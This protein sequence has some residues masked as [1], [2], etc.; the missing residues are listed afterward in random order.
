MQSSTLFSTYSHRR[1]SKFLLLNTVRLLSQMAVAR[2]SSTLESLAEWEPDSAKDR[3]ILERIKKLAATYLPDGWQQWKM[4]P[5]TKE[6]LLGNDLD[7]QILNKI[8][9]CLPTV[10]LAR[11]FNPDCSGLSEKFY[12]EMK[13][14][15]LNWSFCIGLIIGGGPIPSAQELED[16]QCKTSSS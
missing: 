16:L 10:E 15:M 1:D 14:R 2:E 8:R 5:H 9:F 3:E 11:A 6:E 7:P 13:I 4:I 12:K